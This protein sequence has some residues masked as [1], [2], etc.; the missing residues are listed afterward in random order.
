MIWPSGQGREQATPVAV[1]VQAAASP[2]LFALTYTASL[3]GCRV[4]ERRASRLQSPGCE[5]IAAGLA[6][7]GAG[8]GFVRLKETLILLTILAHDH[9]EP[10]NAVSRVLLFQWL[11]PLKMAAHPCAA[12]ETP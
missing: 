4:S 12:W 8:E 3:R 5:M 1:P 10:E 11:S 2:L 9:T 6:L 7:P